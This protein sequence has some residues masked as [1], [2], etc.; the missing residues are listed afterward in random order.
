MSQGWQPNGNLSNIDPDTAPTVDDV[1]PYLQ[2]SML[3]ASKLI[4]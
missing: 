1:R 4:L 3:F 2:E